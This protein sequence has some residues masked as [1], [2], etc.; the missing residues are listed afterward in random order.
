MLY[1]ECFETKAAPLHFINSWL[2]K[3]SPDS[4]V[5]DKYVQTD[6]GRELGKSKAVIDLFERANYNLEF[7]SP[8]RMDQSNAHTKQL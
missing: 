6:L 2:A 3:H 4:T 1:G 8:N 5:W 7:T